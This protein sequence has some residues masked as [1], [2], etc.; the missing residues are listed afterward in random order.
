MPDPI[1]LG[2]SAVTDRQCRVAAHPITPLQGK[3]W[4]MVA[5]EAAG[6]A[7]AEI[8]PS[9]LLVARHQSESGAK[10]ATPPPTHHQSMLLYNEIGD[11][12]W[13]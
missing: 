6:M 9:P 7:D 8:V 13:T 1:I 11:G 10:P 12:T 2:C 4:E 5:I 3:N